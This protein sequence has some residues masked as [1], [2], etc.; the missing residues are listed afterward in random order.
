MTCYQKSGYDKPTGLGDVVAKVA[1]PIARFTKRK[2]IDPQTGELK[3]TSGCSKRK[4]W[5]NGVFPFTMTQTIEIHEAKNGY[6][7][8]LR[9]PIRGRSDKFIATDKAQ[10]I[11]LIKSIAE[12]VLEP[13]PKVEPT[14]NATPALQKLEAKNEA[15]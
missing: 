2:C 3:P 7:I 6:Q 15:S 5:L 11:A 13:A 4:R 10:A 1:T 12:T 9:S 8:N 14:Q